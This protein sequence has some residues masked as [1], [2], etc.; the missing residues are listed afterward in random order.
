[1]DRSNIREFIVVS[2]PENI[3]S[4]KRMIIYI[5]GGAW[6]MG[7]LIKSKG[8]NSQTTIINLFTGATIKIL[9]YDFED[10]PINTH[11]NYNDVVM[12]NNRGEKN[13]KF[14]NWAN[15]QRCKKIIFDRYSVSDNIENIKCGFEICIEDT[16]NKTLCLGLFKKIK[17]K[18]IK[19]VE[20]KKPKMLLQQ[21]SQQP[22]PF[23]LP[24][25]RIRIPMGVKVE[26]MLIEED[27]I[28]IVF[29]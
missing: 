11:L 6:E 18:N 5:C 20:N 13:I 24:E 4:R 3:L 21:P 19:S 17:S 2:S 16:D 14:N 25:M 7:S 10:L 26:S 27:E 1:M 23:P 12:I 15:E 28:V 8:R 29:D 22:Q 9:D